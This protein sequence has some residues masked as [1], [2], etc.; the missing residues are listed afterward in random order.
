MRPASIIQFE[1]LYLASLVIVLIQQVAGYFIAQ[2]MIGRMP[3]G[4]DLPP[5]MGGMFSGILIVSVL[6][7]LI[8]AFGIPLLLWWLAARSRQEVAKWLLLAVSVLSVL[9]W[10][11]GLFMLLAMPNEV[12][13][14][15]GGFTG[16]QGVLVAIDGV[17]ELLGI[18]A[19][20]YLFRADATQWFRTAGPRVNSDVFR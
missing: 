4:A 13:R 11:V 3:G 10:I 5:G 8:F 9:M 1:R 20:V 2:E 19:L 17:G 12:Q 15:L 14:E 16:L 6:I 18:V 7:G